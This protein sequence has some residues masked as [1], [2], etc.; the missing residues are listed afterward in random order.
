[1]KTLRVSFQ[2]VRWFMRYITNTT[3]KPVQLHYA[4]LNIKIVKGV[5][6]LFC[7]AD[8]NF[9]QANSWGPLCCGFTAALKFGSLWVSLYAR[10]NV[11]HF[12][13]RDQHR[14]NR[15]ILPLPSAFAHLPTNTL[16]GRR[17]LSLHV[18]GMTPFTQV[19]L[20]KPNFSIRFSP[21]TLQKNQGPHVRSNPW[22]NCCRGMLESALFICVSIMPIIIRREYNSQYSRTYCHNDCFNYR[23][24]EKR[25]DAVYEV[26]RECDWLTDL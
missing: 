5:R 15:S 23:G 25:C 18:G 22:C 12:L 21:N 24:S 8:K 16:T 11:S 9:M 10:A 17:S 1:M 20:S 6:T 26:R 2:S 3:N 14:G 4:C 7:S 19:A 13:R